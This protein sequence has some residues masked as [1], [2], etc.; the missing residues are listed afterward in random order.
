MLKYIY[1][2]G[3]LSIIW[4]IANDLDYQLSKQLS[5]VWIMNYLESYQLL[6]CWK[7]FYKEDDYQET[8]KKNWTVNQY[9]GRNGL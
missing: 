8:N 2:G 7:R 4:I 9:M 5:F 1:M 3:Q 6:M